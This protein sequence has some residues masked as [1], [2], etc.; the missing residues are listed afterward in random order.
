MRRYQAKKEGTKKLIG[1]LC[2]RITA[3]L[4]AIGLVAVDCIAAYASESMFEVT[5]LDNRQFVVDLRR[6][7]C[8][9]R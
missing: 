6:R 5:C 2:P 1:R 4:E 9:C 3:K 7:R 8:G